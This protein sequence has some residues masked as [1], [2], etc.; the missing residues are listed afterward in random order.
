[1]KKY[2]KSASIRLTEPYLSRCDNFLFNKHGIKTVPQPCINNG[3]IGWRKERHYPYVNLYQIGN[4]ASP[5]RQAAERTKARA[6]WLMGSWLLANGGHP[7]TRVPIED[8]VN[9]WHSIRTSICKR[10]PLLSG[11]NYI[12]GGI[13]LHKP[14]CFL[15]SGSHNSI[16]DLL[17]RTQAD[18]KITLLL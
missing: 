17:K 16:P 6:T 10:E 5:I 1:M 7:D 3:A 14:N 13:Q 2:Y 4:T 8:G 18:I 11:T 12:K 9:P 15:L